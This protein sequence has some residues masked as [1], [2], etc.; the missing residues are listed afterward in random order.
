MADDDLFDYMFLDAQE[1]EEENEL[2]REENEH[3]KEQLRNKENHPPRE[4]RISFN[5]VKEFQENVQSIAADC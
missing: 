2:L 4:E 5:D 1:K 3:L